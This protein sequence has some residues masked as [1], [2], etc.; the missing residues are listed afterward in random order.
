L[1]IDLVSPI[2]RFQLRSPF[3]TKVAVFNRARS[4]GSSE[5]KGGLSE[6]KERKKGEYTP[7]MTKKTGPIL[8]S[9]LL[10]S[11]PEV[12]KKLFRTA[13]ILEHM[14]TILRQTLPENLREAVTIRYYRAGIL[15]INVPS[16]MYATLVRMHENKILAD[17][18]H[19]KEFANVVSLAIKV[20]P[21][22]AYRKPQRTPMLMPDDSTRQSQ[23]A[24]GDTADA[25]FLKAL[26]RLATR[27]KNKR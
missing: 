4:R 7:A 8:L 1:I 26:E 15:A 5:N 20:R 10:Q 17:L 2:R 16:G 12:L 3:S 9:Q 18:A 23:S 6:N 22:S 13:H 25:A 14:Q 27:A 11:Q 24:T 21:G 19:T